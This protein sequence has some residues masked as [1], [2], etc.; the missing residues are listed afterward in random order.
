[1]LRSVAVG[2]AALAAPA[3]GDIGAKPFE[4]VTLA[5][6]VHGFVWTDPLAQPIDGN[7]LFIVNDRDVVV[8]DSSGFPSNA[9]RMIAELRKL[10]DKPV[11]YVVNTHWHDDHHGGNFLYRQAWPGVALVGHHDTRTDLMAR[12]YGDRPKDLAELETSARTMERWIAQ[13]QDDAGKPMDDRR[14]A[15]ARALI[16]EARA[17]A[18]EIGSIEQAPPDLTFQDR[19]VLHRGERTIELLWLGRGNTRGDLVVLLPRERI[20]ATGDLLVYPIPFAFFCYY[21]EWVD[22]LGK[23]DALPADLLFL[24]HGHPQRDRTYL[25]QVREL[26]SSLVAET[27]AAAAAGLTLEQAKERITLQEWKRKLA[28]DDEDKKRAFDAFFIQPAVE[29]ALKQAQGDAASFGPP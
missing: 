5:E 16:G 23:L 6:G 26:L 27:K 3:L 22:T 1:V 21:E 10:T 29:R 14:K 11:S 25:H 24:S 8:V 2:L 20:V 28:G 13:G 15:R 4:I 9:R 12:S 19:L 7:A 18:I 17:A